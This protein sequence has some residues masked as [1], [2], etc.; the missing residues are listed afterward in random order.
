[1][2]LDN[3]RRSRRYLLQMQMHFAQIHAHKKY[4]IFIARNLLCL[5]ILASSKYN[6]I[7]LVSKVKQKVK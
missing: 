2:A 1:M 6:L 7:L 3:E 5:I 4:K